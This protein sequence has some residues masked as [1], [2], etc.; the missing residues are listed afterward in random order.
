MNLRD[1]RHVEYPD[2]FSFFGQPSVAFVVKPPAS[3]EVGW[4]KLAGPLHT[5]GG[6]RWCDFHIFIILEITVGKVAILSRRFIITE[7]VV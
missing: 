5:R 3:L 2:D 7:I 4:I 6:F 1:E